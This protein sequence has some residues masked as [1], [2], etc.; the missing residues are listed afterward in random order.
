MGHVR[1]HN[2]PSSAPESKPDEPAVATKYKL[3]DWLGTEDVIEL[4]EKYIISF[5]S[6]I[7]QKAQTDK[8]PRPTS[9]SQYPVYRLNNPTHE[10]NLV[11]GAVKSL[12][13]EAINLNHGA[14][15]VVVQAKGFR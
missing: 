8:A 14:N 4:C 3:S 10:Q 15:S 5:Y 9:H 13:F 7:T 11:A 2:E 1:E 6:A 12:A